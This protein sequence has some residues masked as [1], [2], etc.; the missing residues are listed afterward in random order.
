MKVI[1][2]ALEGVFIIEPTC[3]GDHRGWF[4]E[5]YH[6]DKLKQQGIN[7]TF[8]QD[9][10]S[11][12]KQKDTIRGLHAQA[13]EFAQAKLVRCTQGKIMDVAVDFRKE[14]PTY[15]KWIKVEL[16][17]EN[18]RQL[19]IPR[20]FLHGFLTLSEDVEVQYKVDNVYNKDSEITIRF[21]DSNISISWEI[22]HPIL[23]EK[24]ENALTVLQY[25]EQV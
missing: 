7:A 2:T 20:G 18:K 5:T 11:F 15:L 16:T 17:S 25:E 3:F 14:S 1:E 22:E 12:S 10:H 19:F 21:D 6:Y 4:M 13:G 23:S 9:N 8:I 24:D